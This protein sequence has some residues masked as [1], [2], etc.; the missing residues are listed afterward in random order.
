MHSIPG[1]LIMRKLLAFDQK[2]YC[3]DKGPNKNGIC[4]EHEFL[5]KHYA[6]LRVEYSGTHHYWF[7]GTTLRVDRNNNSFYGTILRNVRGPK[8]HDED[9]YNFANFCETILAR[10]V[11]VV[12][13]G[14]QNS[15]V[16]DA[17]F[18]Y[19][20]L[21]TDYKTPKMLSDL[22]QYGALFHAYL[23]SEN[24][25]GMSRTSTRFLI[26]KG[27]IFSDQVRDDAISSGYHEMVEVYLE[28][29]GEVDYGM[30]QRSIG[31]NDEAYR[32]FRLLL[33]R[34]DKLKVNRPLNT[35]PIRYQNLLTEAACYGHPRII[36]ALLECPR[37]SLED[38]SGQDAIELASKSG[39]LACLKILLRDERIDIDNI[40]LSCFEF[41]T[42][43]SSRR[44]ISV[45]EFLLDDLYLKVPAP[46]YD[47]LYGEV[48]H[49]GNFEN[50]MSEVIDFLVKY[51]KI[52]RT[53]I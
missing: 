53:S 52:A 4:D 39:N 30:L 49:R 23:K 44:R 27:A 48:R 18:L 19:S 37:F 15:L 45:L 6:K 26:D 29:G 28:R 11:S 34:C 12:D 36:A 9:Y 41:A 25:E 38:R 2:L 21:A 22:L 17:E 50:H 43:S 33:P 7:M 10:H 31:C 24:C 47:R 51:K 3:S 16:E 5:K 35:E 14:I 20:L 46:L 32:V 40:R 1:E 8:K 42:K 13:D